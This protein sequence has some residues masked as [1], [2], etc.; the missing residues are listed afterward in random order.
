MEIPK[1]RVCTKCGIEKDLDSFCKQQD[2]KYGKSPQCR[3]CHKNNHKKYYDSLTA[4][5]KAKKYAD[6][7]AVVK[8]HPERQEGYYL[9]HKFGIA[10]KEMALQVEIQKSVCSFCEKISD[11]LVVDHD[12][13]QCV[14]GKIYGGKWARG[15]RKCIRGLTCSFCNFAAIPWFERNPDRQDE[16]VKAYMKARPFDVVAE[17]DVNPSKSET[18]V[19]RISILGMEAKK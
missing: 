1:T 18:A 12:H 5:Q 17:P 8:A 9:K 10:P 7:R 15:C 13:F 3:E 4:E 2:G 16:K 11:K 6:S 19:R 14:H